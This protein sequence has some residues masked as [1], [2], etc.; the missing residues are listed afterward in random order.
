MTYEEKLEQFKLKPTHELF[1]NKTEIDL[2]PLEFTYGPLNSTGSRLSICRFEFKVRFADF[3]WF[4]PY[5]NFGKLQILQ[6]IEICSNDL[7]V[8]SLFEL[9][10]ATKQE[11]DV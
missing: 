8:I 3:D 5:G 4:E 1:R 7:Q 6:M 9:L 2:L 11:I 10:S